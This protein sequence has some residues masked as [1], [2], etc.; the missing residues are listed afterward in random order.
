[1][2]YIDQPI[3]VTVERGTDG[4][5]TKP[6]AENQATEKVKITV[7]PTPLRDFGLMMNL[8]PITAIQK[9]SPA[10]K[11]GLQIGDRIISIDGKPIGNPFTLESRLRQ[12]AAEGK[13]ATFQIER[14]ADSKADKNSAPQ[15]L[16][17]SVTPHAPEFIDFFQDISPLPL[18]AIGA[19]CEVPTTVAAVQPG[20]P[21]AADDIKPGDEI[22]SEKLLAP[23]KKNS[24]GLFEDEEPPPAKTVDFGKHLSWPG[25]VLEVLP[26]LDP[27]TKVQLEVRRGDNTHTVDITLAELKNDSETVLHSPNRGFNLAPMTVMHRTDSW[28]AAARAG[29]RKRETHC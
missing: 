8:G 23:E 15:H 9:N 10:E 16:T 18:S 13:A 11:A 6:A 7:D 19:A 27:A 29:A 21:A 14:Q 1:M 22:V 17:I 5:K 26:T 3:E 20:S 28:A 4:D 24:P 2:K 25:Y 12:L